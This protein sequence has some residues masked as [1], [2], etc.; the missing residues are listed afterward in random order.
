MSQVDS[1]ERRDY[2]V[3]GKLVP[4]GYIQLT[5]LGSASRL[6]G[7]PAGAR[8]ALIQA[9]TQNVRWRD[10]GTAPTNGI[11]MQLAAGRDMLYTGDL[12]A[13]QFI[14]EAASAELNVTYYF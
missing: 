5:S 12:Q 7:I 13:I 10:D 4:C 3:D 9:V 6:T 11:G 1:K 2:M 8:V 14:E